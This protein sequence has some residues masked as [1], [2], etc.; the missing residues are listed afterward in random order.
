VGATDRSGTAGTAP[1]PAVPDA[2]VSRATAAA[3]VTAAKAR[4]RR[5]VPGGGAAVPRPGNHVIVMFGATG[6][7]A[8]RKLMPG[9]FH[10][11]AAGLMPDRYQII[12]SARADLTG[13]QFRD[14][15]GQA[16][17][18]FGT[19]KPT[20]A[21][22][23]D[24]ARRLSFAS[25]G[26]G[27]GP[28]AAEIDRA[29]REIG[30]TPGRLF[31]LAIPPAAFEP[32]VRM[33]G[34]AGLARGCRVI[35]EKP[36]GTDLASARALNQTVHAI[37]SE[38]Q[39][40]RIDHFLGKESVD[41]ILAF[42]FANGLF[43]PVWNRRH[44]AYVKIDVPET[45]SIEGRADF[46]DHIGAYRDMIVTH[47]FQ[48]L[49]FVAM[50]PPVSLDAR[51]LR[52]ETAKVFDAL[53]PINPG[54]VVRG[55]YAGYRDEPGVAPGSQTETMAAVRAEID[56]WRWAGVPFF[57]RSG[58][59]LA[60]S[61]QVITL[62]FYQPP[63]RMFASQ[64]GAAGRRN[65]I[66]IDFADPGSITTGFLAKEPGATMR[67]GA[68]EMTF[69]YADSF[70]AAHGLEGYERLLLDAML[71]DQTL[72]ITS[73]AVERLWEVSAPL[74]DNPPPVQPYAPGSWGPQQA[75]DHLA[76]R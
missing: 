47:L 67:L 72:F 11:A 29:E 45:L 48:V 36:F 71:G 74:L 63:L 21:A 20:G 49:G 26:S 65:E 44:I 62:G 12:G 41:N 27:A 57:L 23:Q 6:D 2:V 61:R 17:D 13:E 73:G 38:S 52:D 25:T 14:L 35:F 33:L 22:W 59:R 10:L 32:T 1:A 9:L 37:F 53:K 28:L 54:H 30:G 58:K 4:Q 66:V 76:G 64:H 55:Q 3:P 75:L 16:I 39:V 50:E 42:R 43:E 18:E 51:H 5:D 56:N 19:S 7:L 24:F 31:H 15:A 60:A 8:R 69:R 70:G 40:F 68:A 34:G 46:Y